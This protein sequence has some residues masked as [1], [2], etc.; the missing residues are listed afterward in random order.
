VA[1]TTKTAVRV[2]TAAGS[3]CS[4]PG[5]RRDLLWHESATLQGE[6]AHI[7]ALSLGGPR[8][9]DDL[10]A[11]ERDRFENLL[12]LCPNHHAEVDGNTQQWSVE[13]LRKVKSDHEAWIKRQRA[14][15]EITNSTFGSPYYINIRRILLDPSARG[16]RDDLDQLDLSKLDSLV[17]LE[18]GAALRIVSGVEDLISRWEARAVSLEAGAVSTDDVGARV[19]VV[20]RFYTKNCPSPGNHH[21]LTGDITSPPPLDTSWRGKGDRAA[22]SALVHL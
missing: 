10:P 19:K 20:S 12:L 17:G 11:A 13:R 6:I 18:F 5:C 14:L 4:F 15:G 21:Q 1:V 3:M 7:V 16:I 22:R 9:Q 2:W 8:G